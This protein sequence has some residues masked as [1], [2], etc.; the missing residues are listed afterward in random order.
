MSIT[1]CQEA[2]V[3]PVLVGTA[4]DHLLFNQGGAVTITQ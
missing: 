1:V 3:K 4:R 2:G